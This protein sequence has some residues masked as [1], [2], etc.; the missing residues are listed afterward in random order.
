V[1]VVDDDEALRAQLAERLAARGHRVDRAGRG[2]EALERVRA[3]EPE[4]L[5]LDLHLPGMGGLD[6]LRT[7][8]EDDSEAAVLVIT[9]YGDVE[10]AVAAMKLGAFDFVEKP[11]EMAHLDVLVDKALEQVGLRRENRLLRAEIRR[12]R[13]PVV[14]ESAA[15]QAVMRLVDKVADAPTTVLVLGESGTGKEVV[16]RRIHSQSRRRRRPFVAANC[17]AMPSE[18]VESELFGHEQGAFTGAV[19]SRKGLFEMAHGGTLFLDEVGELPL[20][21]QPKLLRVLQDRTFTRVGGTR[22]LEVDV[23]VI[24]ASNRDLQR[25]TAEGEF[26]PD[27]YYRLNVLTIE[28]PPLRERPADIEPLARRFVEHY[29]GLTHHRLEDISPEALALLRAHDWPG[30]VREL[31]NAVERAVVLAETEVLRPEDLPAPVRRGETGPPEAAGSVW[32]ELG[33]HSAVREFKRRLLRAALDRHGGVQ[34]QAAKGL[35]LHPT[36]LSRLLK[37][38]EV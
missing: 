6:V 37:K 28:V 5:I 10:T 16:A 13:P 35:D 34:V 24:A 32:L 11:F 36:Y 29:G 12:H 26:R 15:L 4:V 1:L 9:A 23:R 25:A 33:Y 31:E 19:R 17:A 18:L 7:L 21:L 30:N 8:R 38:L 20:P 14:V 2:E 27:L 22:E 3:Q